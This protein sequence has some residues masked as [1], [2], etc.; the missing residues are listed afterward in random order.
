MEYETPQVSD[1]GSIADHTYITGDF[2]CASGVVCVKP[3]L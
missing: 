3:A 1:F 2:D